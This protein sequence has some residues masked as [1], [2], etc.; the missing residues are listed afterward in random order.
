MVFSIHLKSNSFLGDIVMKNYTLLWLGN[1]MANFYCQFY[2]Y[3]ANDCWDAIL[4]D[5]YEYSIQLVSSKFKQWTKLNRLYGIKYKSSE[6]SKNR[7]YI[8]KRCLYCHAKEFS[9]L[10]K[11]SLQYR[12]V[13]ESNSNSSFLDSNSNYNASY[14]GIGK[15]EVAANQFFFHGEIIKKFKV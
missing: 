11:Y 5:I 4:D 10:T 2:L 3:L 8:R 6:Q 12:S 15:N 14:G 9:Q 7:I 13:S 1:M